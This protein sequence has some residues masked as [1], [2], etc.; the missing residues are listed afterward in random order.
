MASGVVLMSV[1]VLPLPFFLALPRVAGLPLGT[2]ALGLLL[3][4][5]PELA[6]ALCSKLTSS[7]QKL[8][9]H[10]GQC[11]PSGTWLKLT[12]LSKQVL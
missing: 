9:P 6:F 7:F 10:S 12:H 1:L 11:T 8:E 5:W 3:W 2:L 4:G